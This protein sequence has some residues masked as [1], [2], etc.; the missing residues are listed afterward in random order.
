MKRTRNETDRQTAADAEQSCRKRR[1]AME[2]ELTLFDKL[3]CCYYQAVRQIL[4][5]AACAPVSKK[6][7]EEICEATA[8]KESALSILPRLTGPDGPWSCL[9]HKTEDG[10]FSSALG[11]KTL[12]A[13]LSRLQKTWISSVCQD[14]RFLLF[15]TEEE[16]DFIKAGIPALY[17]EEDFY[18]YDRFRNGD[19][20]SSAMYREHFRTILAGLSEKRLLKLS[21]KGKNQLL[22]DLKVLPV[23]LQ[24]SSKDDKFRLLCMRPRNGRNSLPYTLN[25]G[26][27][28]SCRL[29]DQP[30]PVKENVSKPKPSSET[31]SFETPSLAVFS[32]KAKEPAVIEIDGRRNSLERCMLKF[33]D[34][35]KHTVYDEEKGVYICSVY[36]DIQDETE[37]LIDLL[38]FGP[39]IRVLSPERLVAQI[40]E[41]VTR[42]HRWLFGEVGGE[43]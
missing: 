7:M 28:L 32:Q 22:T 14:P 35:E 11:D 3:Y 4:E 23:R 39:V 41:R 26:K 2:Q 36:Y 31:P 38:S 37:L 10:L 43:D 5:E 1:I 27:I 16:R 13:P 6:R 9:L 29:A 12:K 40:R 25:V 33:A 20:Y 15:F 18:Y 34:Y 30:Q 24:Y 17:Q 21:Y 42:Q 8:F 19:P